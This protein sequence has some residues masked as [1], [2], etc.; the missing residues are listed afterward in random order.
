MEFYKKHIFLFNKAC[1]LL[2]QKTICPLV[3]NEHGLLSL[4]ANESLIIKV[5]MY[6]IE[7]EALK[8]IE[9]FTIK[10][11]SYKLNMNECCLKLRK[12]VVEYISKLISHYFD[13][14]NTTEIYLRDSRPGKEG[15][16]VI[17][18]LLKHN[19]NIELID[20]S[21]SIIAEEDL[22]VVLESVENI[23]DDY[24]TLY[25]EG[26][27]LSLSSLKYIRVL[28]A[29]DVK[30][31]IYIGN[32][33]ILAECSKGASINKKRSGKYKVKFKKRNLEEMM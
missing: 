31:E 3:K 18:L 25:L 24:F 2:F 8:D 28:K 17:S 10:N 11:S 7:E 15:C 20:L 27:N 29:R 33:E 19:K 4:F 12:H 9:S 16:D 6:N 22:K 1:N 23:C 13:L 14:N 30:K 21:G 26:V 32:A 5:F